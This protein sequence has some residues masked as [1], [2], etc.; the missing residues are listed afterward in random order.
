MAGHYT[1]DVRHLLSGAWYDMNDTQKEY[2]GASFEGVV[3]AQQN[4]LA[5]VQ[6]DREYP[7]RPY[8]LFYEMA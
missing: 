5:D 6:L 1:A 8:L 4:R 2:L 3:T 7:K